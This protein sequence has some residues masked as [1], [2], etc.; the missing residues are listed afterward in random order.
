MSFGSLFVCFWFGLG[1]FGFFFL[2]LG[3]DFVVV[4][5]L[6]GWFWG[7]VYLWGGLL[8]WVFLVVGGVFLIEKNRTFL[9][10]LTFMH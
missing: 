4:F 3:F 1:G 7:F 5:F 9:H 6:V 10:S 2:G 8:F